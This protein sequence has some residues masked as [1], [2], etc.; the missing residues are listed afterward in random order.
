MRVLNLYAGIGGNAKLWANCEVMAVESNAD[1]ASVYQQ[2]RPDDFVTGKDAKKFL[3]ARHSEYDFIW[4]SPP[5][6]SHSRMIRSG[7]NQ[8]PRYI[9]LDLWQ[10]IIFLRTYAPGSWVVE[11]VRPNYKP[12]IEPTAVI[13]R[14]YFWSNLD[15]FGISDVTRPKGFINKQNQKAKKELLDWLGLQ[16]EPNIYYEGNHDP[17]QIIRNCV[18][19]LIGKAILDLVIAP[20][21][22]QD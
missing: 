22:A 7:R 3:L 2:N 1:I 6:Q 11:N 12:L 8:S 19:P 15:L 17:T 13:G 9:D 5:C 14:H 4:A 16:C 18:H 10:M 21:P 20:N